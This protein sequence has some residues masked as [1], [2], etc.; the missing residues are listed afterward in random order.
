MQD[1]NVEFPNRF[2]MV[3]VEGTDDIYDMIPAPGDVLNPGTLLNK[4]NLLPDPTVAR[5]FDGKEPVP[6][7]PM[8][9]DA[10]DRLNHQVGEI[11]TTRRTD[12][13]DHWALCNGEYLDA[14]QAPDLYR[15]SRESYEYDIVHE[16]EGKLTF[17]D[18]DYTVT[19]VNGSVVIDNTVYSAVMDVPNSKVFVYKWV[20]DEKSYGPVLI[21]TISYT[22]QGNQL[23]MRKCADWVF[24][25]VAYQVTYSQY[26]RAFFAA[27]KDDMVFYPVSYLAEGTYAF[28]NGGGDSGNAT[29]TSST[30]LVYCK[31]KSDGT[32]GIAMSYIT[33]YSNSSGS[34]PLMRV[35]VLELVNGKWMC[36]KAMSTSYVRISPASISVYPYYNPYLGVWQMCNQSYNNTY[37]YL[38][39]INVASCYESGSLAITTA[40][41]SI[42][43]A[44][45]RSYVYG[46]AYDT[47][48]AIWL[49]PYY[50][51]DDDNARNYVINVNSITAPTKLQEMTYSSWVKVIRVYDGKIYGFRTDSTLQSVKVYDTI[52]DLINN[53]GRVLTDENDYPYQTSANGVTTEYLP[54]T[55]DIAFNQGLYDHVFTGEGVVTPG[56]KLPAIAPDASY[57]YIKIKEATDD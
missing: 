16:L 49:I 14:Y 21:Q 27:H 40:T 48:S 32:M 54:V 24:I 56:Y 46:V 38:R 10:L 57:A 41:N 25:E 50:W 20:G 55:N 29:G 5:I 52:E 22:T 4:E 37:V 1:R 11:I 13:G 23:Y 17:D 19:A 44:D 26:Y 31:I 36:V 51:D 34:D 42:W 3:K 30:Q 18:G 12:L 6:K 2:R 47:G 33:T 9:K 53:T 35:E 8:M 28:P 45:G 7:D 15:M 43:S 39:S